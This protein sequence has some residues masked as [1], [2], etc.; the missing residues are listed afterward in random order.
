MSSTFRTPDFEIIENLTSRESEVLHLV[1]QG[2]TNETIA[3]QLVI[4]IGTVKS[5]INHI[6]RKLNAHNRTEVVARA[7]RLGLV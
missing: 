5:H 2:A 3:E 7:R 6:L 1:A 4:T